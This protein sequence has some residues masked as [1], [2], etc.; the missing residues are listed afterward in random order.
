MLSRDQAR[1]YYDRFGAKQDSQWYYED[2]ATDDL[3]EHAGF[4]GAQSVFEFGCGTGRFAET[5]LQQRLPPSATY[6]GIDISSTMVRLASSRITRFGSRAVARITD[7]TMPI[8][9]PNEAYD[10]FVATY[11][12]DLLAVPDIHALLSEARRLLRP[13]GF[14]CLVSLSH[15]ST[16]SSKVVASI[17]ALVHRLRPSLVGGC[18]PIG[19]RDYLPEGVWQVRYRNEVAPFGIPSEVVVAVKR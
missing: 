13:G 9:A 12:L 16:L 4:A 5:L 17:L 8:H 2:P 10:R 11:V 6:L 14:L 19:L 15:G 18:R 7:G 3:I 1:R